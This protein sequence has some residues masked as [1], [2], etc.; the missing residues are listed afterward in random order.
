MF[1]L[2]IMNKIE[3]FAW[4]NE[5]INHGYDLYGEELSPSFQYGVGKEEM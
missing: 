2:E 1:N 5:L 3:L 4:K